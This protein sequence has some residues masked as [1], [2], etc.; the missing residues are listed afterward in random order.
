M[1]GF[2]SGRR[3]LTRK[4]VVEDCRIKLCQ[5]CPKC[6]KRI[7]KTYC[8]PGR[9]DFLCRACWGLSYT[10]RQARNRSLERLISTPA[11]LDSLQAKLLTPLPKGFRELKRQAWALRRLAHANTALVLRAITALDK[12]N[13][14][15]TA[16]GR[17]TRRKT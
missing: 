17:K 6:K 9:A 2:G 10:A 8:P 15:K 14:P 4:V 1:G 13:R 7:R 3:G 11:L 16:G 5:Q 12:I